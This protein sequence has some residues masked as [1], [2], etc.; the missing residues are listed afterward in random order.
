MAAPA[1]LYVPRFF[2]TDSNNN[3]L[4]GGKVFT[5]E[6]GTT[7]DKVAYQDQDFTTPHAN[8]IILDANGSAEI[9]LDGFYKINIKDAD[10]VQ[11][12][13]YPI[14]NVSAAPAST[15]D[16]AGNTEWLTTGAV[17]TFINATSFSVPN[18]ETS[19]YQVGR[20]VRATV[21]AGVVYGRITN[22]SFA[23]SITTVTVSMRGGASLDSGLSVADVGILSATNPSLPFITYEIAD[24]TALTDA[25]TAQQISSGEFVYAADTG[26]ADAYEVDPD[27]AITTYTEGMEVR[28]KIANANATTTPTLD[29]SGVA[30]DTIK[31]G[32]SEALVPGDLPENH[33]AEF[34][35]NGADWILQNPA[36]SPT[37]TVALRDKTRG[38][39][40]IRP[41]A[42]TVDVDA[43]EIILQDSNGL[44]KRVS[45]V[46]LTA[47]ITASGANGLDTGSEASGTWYFI[48]VINNGTTTA[49]LLSA[50]ST[51]PTMPSGYTFKALV[52]AVRND[53][54]SNFIDFTQEG[55]KVNYVAVQTIKDNSFTASAWTAQSL[56]TQYPPT[57]KKVKI[58][59]LSSSHKVGLS[60]R[61]DG[62]AGWYDNSNI[63][64]NE[65]FDIFPT[66]RAKC[67]TLLVRYIATI[68][69]FVTS[70]N[71]S[72]I[73]IGWEYE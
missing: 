25:A 35:H 37:N 72:M 22:S 4:S 59:M 57:A 23:A 19:T 47:N 40:I 45:S 58:A 44:A 7:T 8:P 6:P 67:A 63:S 65:D 50:S 16:T 36:T 5:F 30:A 26:A 14:D 61:S 71:S 13:G 31:K 20:I 27:V 53:G 32:N 49:S 18:D 21:T 46:N 48:W 39:V 43:T 42:A 28:T 34:R 51:A 68:Y 64:S 69:Y 55:N 66:A 9:W 17:V 11:L 10:D 3:L 33:E 52:G 12:D 41:S 54:S 60:P 73:A 29:V 38:L 2:V 1:L 70:T 56:T 15:A 24:A 62:N